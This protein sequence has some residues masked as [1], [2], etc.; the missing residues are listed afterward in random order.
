MVW[1]SWSK[2]HARKAVLVGAA[3]A[4]L[5]LPVSAAAQEAIAPAWDETE[6]R[7]DIA[8]RRERAALLA[9]HLPD[10]IR[11]HSAGK[12]VPILVSGIGG[13]SLALSLTAAPAEPRFLA[14][15]AG[16]A[17]L[18]AGGIAALAVPEAYR[19][20]TVG[21]AALLSQG[22]VWLGLAFFTESGFGRV[23][24]VALSSGYYLSG[25]LSCLNLALSGYPPVSRLR[26]DHALVATSEW[27]AR[28]SGAQIASIERDLLT[29]APAIPSWAIHLPIALGGVAAT[30]PAWDGDL[31]AE[32]RMLSLTSGLLASAWSLGAMFD[33]EH[34]VQSYQ[35]DLRRAGLQVA[36]SGPDS[37][38]GLTISGKF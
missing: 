3:M 30:V 8:Q 23:A 25:L 16:S 26:A 29:T 1:S 37:N 36:P 38:V 6:R 10:V 2:R 34:P 20:E 27:R 12:G 13:A 31:P 22:S 24:P 33:P 32:T 5:S 15:T 19:R 18:L 14:L 7:E 9:T 21:A 11:L 4:R 28:L 17:T 35:R